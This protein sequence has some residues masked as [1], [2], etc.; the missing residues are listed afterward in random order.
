MMVIKDRARFLNTTCHK[1][2]LNTEH[3]VAADGPLNRQHFKAMH[4][5]PLF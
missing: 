3:E 1:E 4:S 2:R 5:V